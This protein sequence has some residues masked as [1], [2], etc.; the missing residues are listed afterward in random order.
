[1]IRR[2]ISGTNQ[3][4]HTIEAGTD[5]ENEQDYDED[6]DPNTLPEALHT[7]VSTQIMYDDDDIRIIRPNEMEDI[8]SMKTQ[9]TGELDENTNV[10]T[11]TIQKM[12]DIISMLKDSPSLRSNSSSVTMEAVMN[13]NGIWTPNVVI[14]TVDPKN[15]KGKNYADSPP[16]NSISLDKEL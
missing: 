5:S 11:V 7:L 10:E 8:N 3:M 1:M 16:I 12:D 13:L 6:I 4:V 14:K 2:S 9:A 15:Y